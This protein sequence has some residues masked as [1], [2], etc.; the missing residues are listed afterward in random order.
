ML[1]EL[2]EIEAML[3]DDRL[4]DGDRFALYGAQQAL[5]NV[6]EPDVCRQLPNLSTGPTHALVT[7]RAK[8]GIDRIE[9]QNCWN[10]FDAI[11]STNCTVFRRDIVPKTNCAAFP[12]V[13]HFFGFPLSRVRLAKTAGLLSYE[14]GELCLQKRAFRAK[15]NC[16]STRHL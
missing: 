10:D 15:G 3:D 9:G 16:S 14:V 1:A 13:A 12:E 8:R 11:A 4:S 5:R 2:I 6:L 7:R